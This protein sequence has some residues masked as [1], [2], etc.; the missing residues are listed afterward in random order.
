MKTRAL[1]A[2]IS[3]L[4]CI[5]VHINLRAQSNPGTENLV[6]QW[7][8]DDGTVNDIVGDKP[9]HGVLHEGATVS[10]KALQLTEAGQYLSFSGTAIAVD[11][12]DAFSQEIW[13]T[14]Q[15]GANASFAHITYFGQIID[16]KGYN[17][18]SMM[19][20]R[21]DNV[22]RVE[23]T[24]ESFS[25]ATY[26]D[27]KEYDDGELHQFV[28]VV[29]AD[30]LFFYIDGNLIDKKANPVPL[31]TLSTA[32]AYIGK[33]GFS[34]DPT[35]LGSVSKY[36]IYN[37][38]LNADEVLFLYESGAEEEPRI[39][40]SSSQLNFREPG[41]IKLAVWGLNLHEPVS[42]SAS[43]GFSV[44]QSELPVLVN[45]DSLQISFNGTASASGIVFLKSGGVEKTIIVEGSVEP[46]I[47]I[48]KNT[49]ILDELSSET[50]FL[51]TGHNLASDIM[52]SA[53]AGISFSQNRIAAD[54]DNA[55]VTV[56]YD[57]DSR[58]SGFINLFSGSASVN[59]TL[60]AE[61]TDECFYKLFP[62]NL[63]QDP[64]LNYDASGEGKTSI[65]TKPEYVYCGTSS[66]KIE[67]NGQLE[68]DL[69]G[70]LKPNTEYRMRAKV[71][72]YHPRIKSGDMGLVT[73][74]LDLDS[75]EHPQYYNL[76]KE[77]MDSACEYYNKYTPFI[78][79][80]YVY[81]NDGIPTAQASYL[82]SIGYGS[83]TAYMWVGTTIHELAHYF[84]SGTTTTWRSLMSSRVWAGASGLALVDELSGAELHGD[85]THFWPHGIN[86]RSE[87]TEL[88]SQEAQ[89]QGLIDATKVVKA[90]L[91][92][93]CNIPTNNTVAGIGIAGWEKGAE[94]LFN[95]VLYANEWNEIDLTFTT[96]AELAQTPKLY[97]TGEEGYIDNWEL[98]EVKPKTTVQI[99][100]AKGWN[101]VSLPLELFDMSIPAVFP[102]ASV[103]KNTE[104]FYDASLPLK[105]NSLSTIEA[106]EGYF[107][108]NSTDE[109]IQYS[110]YLY[111]DTMAT[112]EP[113]NGQWRLIGFPWYEPVLVEDVLKNQTAQPQIIKNFDGVWRAGEVN[114]LEYINP[115]KGYFVK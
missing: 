19:P 92:D 27:G 62:R 70:V 48:S 85:Q 23:I 104:S 83:N 72:K 108:Y 98:Y 36:S 40:T 15:K 97:F 107:V 18:I 94:D 111:A 95:E 32:S 88:G 46:S 34:S 74:T 38:S 79:D 113:E 100:L 37:K 102:N 17:Y 57:G 91:V 4:L 31:S 99:S 8:F 1:G 73:Y 26:V 10:N 53:P 69:T 96:G 105:L 80:V 114:S 41:S 33:S 35:W 56:S 50:Q 59:I 77:A 90:M 112:I 6:H 55:I 52:L 66:G 51:V 93:D 12:Y 106:G 9:V 30:S 68:R 109:I 84:G 47:S 2:Y 101:I 65:N 29:N 71:Y 11:S 20:A 58:S 87:I 39:I 76:I 49:I 81:Y 75:A 61:R 89:H 103:V 14:S 64:G 5:S 67:E 16:G 54:A 45:G 43:E 63:I 22:S 44:D 13:F 42:V 3:I 60:V 86:Y 78:K 28:S 21:G 24:E 115:V 110:G 7:T 82:G 25:G